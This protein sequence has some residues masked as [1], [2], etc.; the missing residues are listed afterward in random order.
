MYFLSVTIICLVSTYDSIYI[1]LRVIRN[2]NCAYQLYCINILV[3]SV[4]RVVYSFSLQRNW[5]SLT[6]ITG[7]ELASVNFTKTV[8]I[9]VITCV[10]VFL[11]SITGAVGNAVDFDQ[12]IIK[13]CF[14]PLWKRS[15]SNRK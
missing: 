12:V 14:V 2:I 10:H 6:K 15:I 1:L 8:Q 13:P 5:S 3:I 7:D 11:F 4:T 9:I